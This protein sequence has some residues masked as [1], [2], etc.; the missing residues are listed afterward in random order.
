MSPTEGGTE[1]GTDGDTAGGT[2]VNEIISQ[3]ENVEH[4]CCWKT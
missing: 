3:C 1:G 4:S 2:E